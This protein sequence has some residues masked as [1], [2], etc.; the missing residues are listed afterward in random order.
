MVPAIGM[1][2]AP[3]FVRG[4]PTAKADL[5]PKVEPPRHLAGRGAVAPISIRRWGMLSWDRCLPHEVSAPEA[6]YRKPAPEWSRKRSD[7]RT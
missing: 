6:P 5:D 1:Q 4:A 3:A 7:R 2:V